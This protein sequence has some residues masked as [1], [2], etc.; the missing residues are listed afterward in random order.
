MK[1]QMLNLVAKCGINCGTCPW[2]PYPRK[3][4]TAEDFEQY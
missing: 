4:M 3:D 2:G 1:G